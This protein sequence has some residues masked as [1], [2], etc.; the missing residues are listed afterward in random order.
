M[1]GTIKNVLV[2]PPYVFQI[3]DFLL[4]SSDVQ[5]W[6]DDAVESQA[7]AEVEE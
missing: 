7:F 1:A 4:V 3:L 5:S 6:L 2:G